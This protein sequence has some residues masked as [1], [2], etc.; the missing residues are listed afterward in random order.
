MAVSSGAGNDFVYT[1]INSSIDALISGDIKHHGFVD[2]RNS[3]VTV[4]DAGHYA[5]ENILC[6]ML[7]QKLKEEFP[8]IEFFI[9]ETNREICNYI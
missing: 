9:P 5:T 4:I 6:E 2:A 3:G 1:C 8:E 7:L